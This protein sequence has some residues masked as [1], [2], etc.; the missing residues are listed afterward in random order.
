M[1]GSLFSEEQINCASSQR[2]PHTHAATPAACLPLAWPRRPKH[3]G[4]C[5]ETPQHK[6]QGLSLATSSCLQTRP[7]HKGPHT[8]I[9]FYLFIHW[10]W[11]APARFGV[12]QALLKRERVQGACSAAAPTLGTATECQGPSPCPDAISPGALS[13]QDTPAT[14]CP[15]GKKEPAPS[16]HERSAH[17]RSPPRQR[18]IAC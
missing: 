6:A 14:P 12:C 9:H 8:A 7:N 11:P 16:P 17:W 2:V 13:P 5:L 4:R 18:P 3:Q 10:Q 1:L 15:G